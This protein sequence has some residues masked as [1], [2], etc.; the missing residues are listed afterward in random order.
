LTLSR[1]G[2]LDVYTLDLGSQVLTRMTFDPGIDTEPVW[3]ADGRKL[4]LRPTGPVV[5]RFMKRH[6]SAE[7]RA[8]PHLRGSYNAGR[9]FHPTASIWRWCMPTAAIIES[10]CWTGSKAMQVLTQGRQ[11]ESPSFVPT[12]PP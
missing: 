10:Q 9:E 8:P 4:Y 11:D 1:N 6:R 7:Q 12:A 5:R 3:S 2:D